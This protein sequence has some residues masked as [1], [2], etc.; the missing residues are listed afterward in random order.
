MSGSDKISDIGLL[1]HFQLE[2]N[3]F[4]PTLDHSDA[5]YFED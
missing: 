2:T 3:P 5:L 1:A 4:S